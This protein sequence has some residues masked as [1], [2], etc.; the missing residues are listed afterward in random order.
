MTAEADPYY[1]GGNENPDTGAAAKYNL[2]AQATNP[3]E[4]W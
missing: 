1:E 4:E 3:D 2:G